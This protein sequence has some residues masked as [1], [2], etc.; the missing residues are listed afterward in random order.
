MKSLL[1]LSLVVSAILLSGC[2]ELDKAVA[3]HMVDVKVIKI[4]P[5]KGYYVTFQRLDNNQVIE[6]YVSKRCSNYTKIRVGNTYKVE[7]TVWENKQKDRHESY[8]N[9]KKV[10]CPSN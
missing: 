7:V 1:K 3:T 8:T 10:F 5:P 4:D 6:E 9:L 2:M